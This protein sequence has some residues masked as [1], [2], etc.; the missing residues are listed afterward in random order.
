M[1]PQGGPSAHRPDSPAAAA[2]T[3][4]VN[5]Q[6]ST[7]DSQTLLREQLRKLEA[8]NAFDQEAQRQKEAARAAEIAR[9]HYLLNNPV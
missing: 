8:Q 3:P 7:V 2:V 9:I 1:A 6:S 5:G 4:T